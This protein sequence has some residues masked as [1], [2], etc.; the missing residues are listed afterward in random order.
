MQLSIGTNFTKLFAIQTGLISSWKAF[1]SSYT[2]PKSDLFKRHNPKAVKLLIRL[3]LII[4]ESNFKYNFQESVY[5]ICDWVWIVKCQLIYF[6][7]FLRAVHIKVVFPLFSRLTGEKILFP[8]VHIWNISPPGRDLFRR[9][10]RRKNFARSKYLKWVTQAWKKV[11]QFCC[12][13]T[14]EGLILSLYVWWEF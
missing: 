2:D 5:P 14:Y 9:A 10:V 8:C 4:R 12:I 13:W 7:T 6:F 11:A 3:S 1:W